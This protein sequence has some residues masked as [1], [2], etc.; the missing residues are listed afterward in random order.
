MIVSA[1][2]LGKRNAFFRKRPALAPWRALAGP[3]LTFHLMV[4]ALILFRANS[5]HSGFVYLAHLLPG[6]QSPGI[7]ALRFR[8]AALLTHGM[9]LAFIGIGFLL[10]ECVHRGAQQP[11]W[12]ARFGALPW[13]VRWAAYYLMLFIIA[14]SI[15]KEPQG[16]IY[17]QF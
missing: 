15:E 13:S 14:L 3:L 9:T 16:F 6:L 7:P 2:T 10:M 1:L 5:L 4:L 17:A 8:C 11:G 12:V